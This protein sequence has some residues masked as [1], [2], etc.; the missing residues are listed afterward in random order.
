MCTNVYNRSRIFTATQ[1]AKEAI[2]ASHL[3]VFLI[4][5]S[6]FLPLLIDNQST[7]QLFENPKFHCLTIHIDASYEIRERE[8]YQEND[9]QVQYVP[10]KQ[11]ID[12][13]MKS[14]PRPQL[15]RLKKS[16]GLCS[17]RAELCRVQIKGVYTYT[18]SSLV[19]LN[20]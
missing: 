11:Q 6:G 10:S 17:K 18:H 13:F 12:I 16:L 3:Y 7:I 4:G 8:W 9:L 1:G 2:W 5:T 20:F 15:E 19:F 14:F